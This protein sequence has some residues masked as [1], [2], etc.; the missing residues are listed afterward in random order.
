MSEQLT[1]E[2]ATAYHTQRG[3]Y[4][5]S[6]L[7]IAAFRGQSDLIDD[8]RNGRDDTTSLYFGRAAHVW[9]LEG[10]TKFHT[11]Y[12]VGGP[13]NPK[14]GKTFGTT[15]KTYR[16]WADA[17]LLPAIT[18]EEFDLIQRMA[19]SV[20]RE[21]SACQLLES[22]E[23]ERTGRAEV[24][25]VPC[26][27]RLDWL[28]ACNRIVDYKTTS[29]LA[30][31][32]IDCEQYGYLIQQAF[33]RQVV[34]EIIGVTCP[35]YLIACEK[36]EETPAIV[37]R[38]KDDLLDEQEQKNIAKIVEVRELFFRLR[39]EKQKWLSEPSSKTSTKK[40][41]TDRPRQQKQKEAPAA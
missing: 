37:W 23:A 20:R 7:L 11:E 24:E 26:Q 38:I 41:P 25:G 31:F 3:L 5:T 16:E 19:D 36:S 33:Y 12:T 34:R 8:F 4:L 14:T 10:P 28:T 6:H 18:P 1:T 30:T 9:L 29:C 39:K 13:V 40:P 35:C 21:K 32:D 2:D 22:G 17:Q 15:S 27:V